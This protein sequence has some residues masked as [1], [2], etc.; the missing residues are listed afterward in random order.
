MHIVET[1]VTHFWKYTYSITCTELDEK[2]ETSHVCELSMEIDLEDDCLQ[3]Y[4]IMDAINSLADLLLHISL[5]FFLQFTNEN[6]LK[7]TS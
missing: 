3:S 2:I 4:D 6:R 7:L 5:M 1:I